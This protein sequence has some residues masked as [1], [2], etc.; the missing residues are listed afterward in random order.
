MHVERQRERSR[1]GVARDVVLGR[2]E[3]AGRDD[4]VDGPERGRQHLRE[5]LDIVAEHGLQAD[6]VADRVEPL[7]DRE[8]VRVDAEW[9]QQLAADRDDA[10]LHESQAMTDKEA[11][12]HEVRVDRRHH[13]VGHDAETAGQLFES[14]GR[15]RLQD[16][17]GAKQEESGERATPAHWMH[18]QR[19]EHAHD[20]VD[21]DRTRI[22]AAEVA[23]RDGA[24]PRADRESHQDGRRLRCWRRG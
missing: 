10:G 24:S 4:Q 18:E 5:L 15:V 20:F 22:G 7:G 6:V 21:H 9:R 23:L 17:E 16:V 13:V 2:A 12:E 19:D 3:A 8:R 11:P 1:E 14:I